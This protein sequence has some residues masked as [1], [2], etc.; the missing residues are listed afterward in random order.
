M[1]WFVAGAFILIIIISLLAA[2]VKKGPDRINRLP[3]D[4]GW[5]QDN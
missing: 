5:N 3:E 4:D 1:V 2:F